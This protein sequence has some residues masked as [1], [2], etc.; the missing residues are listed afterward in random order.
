MLFRSINIV[1]IVLLGNW[2]FG[3]LADWESQKRRLDAGE[4]SEIRFVVEDNPHLPGS[5]PGQVWSGADAGRI[6]PLTDQERDPH[7]VS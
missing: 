4:I 1:S 7:R 2:A 6:T 3:A 5:L